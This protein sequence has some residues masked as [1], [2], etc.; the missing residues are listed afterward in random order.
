MAQRKYHRQVFQK[1][2]RAKVFSLLIK[3]GLVFVF[4]ALLSVFSLFI[5]FMKDLPRPEKFTERPF[6]ES[7][8]IY[9]RTGKVLLYEVYGE[10]KRGVIPLSE[11]PGYLKQAV[12]VTEDANFYQHFGLDWK[13]I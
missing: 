8:K 1:K 6:V 7:T 9:D 12:I 2:K 13:G 4:L 5:F 3:F 10:E 11:I